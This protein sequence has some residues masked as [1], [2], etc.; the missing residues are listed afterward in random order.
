M[1]LP[2]VHGGKCWTPAHAVGIRA[3]TKE[4]FP[5]TPEKIRSC[6]RSMERELDKWMVMRA[7]YAEVK[8]GGKDLH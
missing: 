6:L 5:L 7:N 8:E 4:P 2:G 1:E 3:S